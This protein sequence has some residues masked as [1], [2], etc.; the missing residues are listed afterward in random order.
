MTITNH[1]QILEVSQKATFREIKQAYRRLVKRF[2]PDINRES[3]NNEKI[4]LINAAY[5][6]L[7]DSQRRQVYDQQLLLNNSLQQQERNNN[8]QNYY[9]NYRQ[10]RRKA[11]SHQWQWLKQVYSPINRLIDLIINPLD[12]QI[13]QLSADI[14]DD[15]LM[16]NFQS[17]L[18]DCHYY[19]NQ[20][21]QV[22]ASQPNPPKLALAAA[23]IYYCL[24][25]IG[26][27]IEQLEWF[28]LNYDDY[29]LHTG[30]ELF[31]IAQGLHCEAQDAVQ[32]IP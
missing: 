21:E 20:A 15:Q 10:T 32:V 19:L 3:A 17:Y 24:N 31:R 29:Y 14:F 1:Y 8:P 16:E 4:I 27:G 13:E 11:D 2:H 7:R 18:Q 22:F 30:Q 9:H 23:S 28:T 26:D 25:Q 5:E 6:I 12:D